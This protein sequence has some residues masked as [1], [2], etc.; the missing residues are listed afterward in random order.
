M[1]IAIPFSELSDLIRKETGQSIGLA[2]KSADE[3]SVN[4]T[5]SIKVPLIG[6]VNKD[7]QAG[8]KLLEVSNEKVVFQLD[9]GKMNGVLDILSSFL[10]GK[11]PTGLVESFSDGIAS[12]RLSAIPQLSPVLDRLEIDGISLDQDRIILNA[13]TK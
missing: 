11:L 7:I 8:L 4:Y 3:V 13:R 6:P 12:L 9:A 1:Q 10:L 5:A 2:Y